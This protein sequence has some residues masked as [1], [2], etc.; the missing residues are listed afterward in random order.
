ML[1]WCDLHEARR[2]EARRSEGG[3]G[4]EGRQGEEGRGAASVSA[5]PLVVGPDGQWEAEWFGQ[6]LRRAPWLQAVTHHIYPLGAGSLEMSELASKVRPKWRLM[7]RR[8]GV[9]MRSAFALGVGV[10]VQG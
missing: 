9:R 5:K 4:H 10:G 8:V 3:Q 7:M 2:G 6:L 1:V